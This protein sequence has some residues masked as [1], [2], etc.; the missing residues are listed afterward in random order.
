MTLHRLQLALALVL[1]A[2]SAARSADDAKVD[3]TRD[4]RPILAANCLACHGQDAAHR[5][6]E[7]RLDQFD[8]PGGDVRGAEEVI[9]P[10][11]PEES[12]LIARITSDDPEMRMPPA[13]TGKTLE[14]AQIE[15]LRRW[16][17]AG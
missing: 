10:G 3:Y 12:E 1:V 2:A 4:V 5:E 13:S 7:L 11:S 16:I 15:T 8:S 9:A 17:A 14:P 6:A